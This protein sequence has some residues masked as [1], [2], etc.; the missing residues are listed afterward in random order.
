[1][2][3]VIPKSDGKVD[4]R[5]LSLVQNPE[6]TSLI[7]PIFSVDPNIPM[8]RV[9]GH[10]TLFRVDPW[11]G[12][13]TAFHV[14][15]ELLTL[16][17]GQ[18]ALKPTPKIAALET[19]PI[20]YGTLPIIPAFWRPITGIFSCLSLDEK[21]FVSPKIRNFSEL[22]AVLCPRGNAVRA[23]EAKYLPLDLT[24]SIPRQGDKITAFGYADLDVDKQ[25]NGDDRP[26]EQRLYR[27]DA[28]V[29]DV[30]K[31]DISSGRPWPLARVEANWPGGMSGGPVF[32][33]AGVVIGVVSTGIPGEN[34]GTA[35]LFAGWDAGR[36]TFGRL[37]PLNPGWVQAF[38]ALGSNDAILEV[39]LTEN[40]LVPLVATGAAKTVRRA[41]VD[42]ASGDFM[43]RD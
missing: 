31:P 25:G 22:A 42:L 8:E 26:L 33:Q 37:D 38:L 43:L 5:G 41:T 32:N 15:E 14:I 23:L 4:D 29:V 10:G 40:D 6:L 36:N 2:K 39:S 1:M 17:G 21:P 7:H 20:G 9:L 3:I 19:P 24:G 35:A 12:C 16:H 27:S 13:A 11:D 30:Q 34:I 28:I 18:I